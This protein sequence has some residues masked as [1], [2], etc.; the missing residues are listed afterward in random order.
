MVSPHGVVRRLWTPFALLVVMFLA[1]ST[2]RADVIYKIQPIVK[3]GDTVGG[4]TI[5]QAADFEVGTLND[6]G[7]LVFVTENA[8][9]GEVLFLYSDGTFTPIALAGGNAP[10][11]TWP[12]GV[13]FGNPTSMNQLGNMV[14]GAGAVQRNNLVADTYRWDAQTQKVTPVAL[15]GMPAANNLV[16]EQGGS[17]RS[18]INNFDE[19]TFEAVV[20]NAAGQL[21]L[22]VFFQGRD[23]QIV[24]VA[25]P[26]QDLPDGKKIDA[27]F[28]PSLNDAGV[29]AF[30]VAVKGERAAGAYL[31]E[32]GAILPLA[33]IGMDAPGGAKLFGVGQVWVNN[34]THNVLLTGALKNN[35]PGGLY[36][37]A[38]GKLT[39][40]VER[41][42]VTPDGKKVQDLAWVSE[43]NDAGQ[44]AFLAT[45]QGGGTAAYLL[46]A[47]GKLSLILKSGT[48]SDLGVIRSVG[49]PSTSPPATGLTL[50]NR[51]QVAVP[52]RITGGPA[53]IVLLTPTTQ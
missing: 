48:T 4:V 6:R 32:K 43:P 44:H 49:L 19:I 45:L 5:K 53:M 46:D 37:L 10:G 33:T 14:F 22:G 9:G 2:T 38:E 7:Q 50:N 21:R 17:F 1:P 25:L 12:A 11:G 51:G 16:F 23:G 40:L 13:G 52:I 39:A 3:Q 26:D 31:W 41:G 20:K 15:K 8:A 30:G 28:G 18:V 24:P 34:P 35:G 42:Q 27:A 47:D 36:R 29:I